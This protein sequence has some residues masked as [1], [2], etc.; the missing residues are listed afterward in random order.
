MTNRGQKKKTW[1]V[2]TIWKHLECH[3]FMV[4]SCWATD[5]TPEE[6][7]V[8]R[9]SPADFLFLSCLWCVLA[10]TSF[11]CTYN[12]WNLSV[13]GLPEGRSNVENI[14]NRVKAISSSTKTP[15]IC[16]GT[17]CVGLP[18]LGL[19]DAAFHGS[20][21]TLCTKIPVDSIITTR[22]GHYKWL[23]PIYCPSPRCYLL[24]HG[25]RKT[26]LTTQV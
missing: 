16:G 9:V 20:S 4:P 14:G 17:S 5:G 6:V 8:R 10:F 25:V 18:M 21:P 24:H 12:I 13:I 19:T 23:Y 3:A 15:V 7:I 11:K 26:L 2:P 1:S 22:L